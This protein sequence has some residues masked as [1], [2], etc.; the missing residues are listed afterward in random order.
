MMAYISLAFSFLS[1]AI[2]VRNEWVFERRVELNRFEDGVHVIRQY[3]DYNTMLLRFWVWDIE[4]FKTP[5]VEL[6]GG[7]AVSSPERPA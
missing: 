7:P 2:L 4:K 5:N 1:I 6:R 3:A